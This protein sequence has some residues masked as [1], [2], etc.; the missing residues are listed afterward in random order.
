[1]C[2]LDAPK[3]KNMLRNADKRRILANASPP[4]S[5]IHDTITP[6]PMR[7]SDITRLVGPRLSLSLTTKSSPSPE[8]RGPR[9]CVSHVDDLRHPY[10]V[11]MEGRSPPG[12][13]RRSAESHD[14]DMDGDTTTS[15]G[16]RQSPSPQRVV[17]RPRY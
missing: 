6:V 13:G 16:P 1:M 3:K 17:I 14:D 10:D 2:F 12:G 5:A 9:E 4:N 7:T 15:E 8:V 11:L